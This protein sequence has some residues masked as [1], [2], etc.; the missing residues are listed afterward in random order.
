MRKLLLP[1]ILMGVAA[2]LAYLFA[3]WTVGGAAKSRYGFEADLR[4]AQIKFLRNNSLLRPIADSQGRPDL[5][6][7]LNEVNTL[8]AWYF[9]E[10]VAPLE[11]E[12]SA[13]ADPERLIQEARK[14]ASTEGPNQRKAQGNLPI[15]EECYKMVR[16]I[17]DEFR[18]AKYNA[19]ASDFKGSIRMDVRSIRNEGGKLRWE[20]VLWGGIG[21]VVYGGWTQ[22][23]FKAPTPEEIKDYETRLK[24]FKKRARPGEEEP[25]HPSNMPFAQS[26]AGSGRPVLPDFDGSDYV[27]TFPA[28]AMVNYF[29][30]PTAPP[31]A[32]RIEMEFRLKSRAVSGE[33]QE[34]LF[35]FS[36][37]VD[38]AWKGSWDGVQKIEAAPN[39]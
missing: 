27:P 4:A 34:M 28:G 3:S 23:Y 37:P 24:E 29:F 18:G 9:R 35:T 36:L 12:Y 10:V 14:A 32:E 15:R 1:I 17:F 20:V 16:A 8:M 31:D 25:K 6:K 19:V 13:A 5:Q 22:K 38:A 39:Y 7:Y 2:G 26:Q 11:K 33:D 21:P 30:A